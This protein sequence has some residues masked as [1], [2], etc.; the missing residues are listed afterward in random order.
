MEILLFVCSFSL[1]LT[2]M[3]TMK[4]MVEMMASLYCGSAT[5][6]SVTHK[7]FSVFLPQNHIDET[8]ESKAKQDSQRQTLR[9]AS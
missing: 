9:A 6:R 1:S 4:R 7:K 5:D 8:K 2:S 3:L